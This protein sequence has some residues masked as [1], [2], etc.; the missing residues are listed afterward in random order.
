MIDIRY[1]KTCTSTQ[2]ALRAAESCHEIECTDK[3]CA[4]ECP[5]RMA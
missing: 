1:V 2:Q 4:E 3:M 5:F